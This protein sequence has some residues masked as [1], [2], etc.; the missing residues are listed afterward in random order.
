M[1]RNI[2]KML[3]EYDRIG[4]GREI[5]RASDFMNIYSTV[6]T[7]GCG[8]LRWDLTSFS[9]RYGVVI[10]YRLA[11]RDAAKRRKAMETK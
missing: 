3:K 1:H 5:L 7:D 6:K 8:D 4:Q 11:K 2:D 10:G 9:L